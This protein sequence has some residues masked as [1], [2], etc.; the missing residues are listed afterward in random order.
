MKILITGAEGQLGHELCR[1]FKGN[2]LIPLNHKDGDITQREIIQKIEKARPDLVIHG[3]AYTD[4]DGCENNPD[5][6]YLVNALGTRN[7]VLGAH[8][9]GADLVYISTDYVFDGKKEVPYTEFDITNPINVYGASKLGGEWQVQHL[10]HKF[11]IVRSSWLYGLEGKNFVKTILRL[12][13][14]QETL[15][16][17]N[18]QIGC[19]TYVKDLALVIFHLIKTGAYGIYH[20]AADGGCTWFDF[21]EE[22]LKIS[23]IQKK[24][25]PISSKEL[26]RPA[27]RPPNSVLK[28]FSLKTLGIKVR[29]WKEQIQDCL[30]EMKIGS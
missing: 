2:D 17:V 9:V 3:A 1:V 29:G 20:A 23:K 8:R 18:D 5:R 22:I 30:K 28:N 15:K 14:E 13:R 25:N 12:A 7:V 24:V 11:Y 26:G 6:A 16:I 27:K 4:V 10:T 21:T 19:P